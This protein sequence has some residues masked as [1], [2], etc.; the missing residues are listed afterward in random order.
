MNWI[1]S[2]TDV[3]S[4]STST[5]S[6]C[7]VRNFDCLFVCISD[8]VSRRCFT[9][10]VDE[11]KTSWET[12]KSMKHAPSCSS[13]PR[14]SLSSVAGSSSFMLQRSFKGTIQHSPPSS[15]V[16][17]RQTSA[18][19]QD[20]D[21]SGLFFCLCWVWT[22][23]CSV[24]IISGYFSFEGNL[25]WEDK[26]D[27]HRCFHWLSDWFINSLCSLSSAPPCFC[28]LCVTLMR[29]DSLK[30]KFSLIFKKNHISG[31]VYKIQ[32]D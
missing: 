17:W 23:S 29:S 13:A 15:P 30:E 26:N 7:S 24:H 18:L 11:D 5:L 8:E 14:A 16:R 6:F 4:A 1:R 12:W 9:S 19:S 32:F 27:S 3:S 22:N 28:I 31:T 20:G 10:R 25:K 2:G 21:E